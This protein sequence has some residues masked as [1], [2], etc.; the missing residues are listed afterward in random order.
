M[1]A[2]ETV[3][4]D[5]NLVGIKITIKKHGQEIGR[6]IKNDPQVPD[7]EYPWWVIINCLSAVGDTNV[8]ANAMRSLIVQYARDLGVIETI[9]LNDLYEQVIGVNPELRRNLRVGPQQNR[10]EGN[11]C[12]AAIGEPAQKRRFNDV[13]PGEVLTLADRIKKRVVGQDHVIDQIT[14]SIEMAKADL[15]NPRRP[16][17]SFLLIGPTGVGKTLIF[18][19]LFEELI[20]TA[21]EEDGFI[22][23]D[24][25]EYCL[26]HDIAKLIGAPPGYIMS[27]KGG[28]LTNHIAMYPFSVVLFDEIE[29][30]HQSIYNLQMK[31][32]DKGMLTDSQGN[33][34]SLSEAIIGMTS[35]VGVKEMQGLKALGFGA[36]IDEET[37]R[38]HLEKSLFG[39]FNPEWLGRLDGIFYCR[40]LAAEDYL[41]IVDLELALAL[42]W[43]AE[44]RKIEVSWNED[45]KQLIYANGADTDRFGARSIKGRVERLFSK[46]LSKCVLRNDFQEGDRLEAGVEKEKIIFERRS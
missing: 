18:E 27:D 6:R 2:Y 39:H 28:L 5:W 26:E 4:H 32:T 7:A 14:E 17:G 10:A 38:E 33:K 35:N 44:R 45:V 22:C 9:V 3:E 20:K 34:V 46:P 37:K 23:I 36:R 21:E 12:A 13:T 29:K 42:K 40:S 31:I 25:P 1:A 41:K 30:A 19:V 8:N 11:K 24:C 15:K 43:F 16:K